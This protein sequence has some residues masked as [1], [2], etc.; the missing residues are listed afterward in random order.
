MTSY[1]ILST[2]H[3]AKGQEW[4]AVHVLNVVDGCIPSDMATG[5]TEELEE[6]R[7]LLYVAMTRARDQLHLLVP[8]RFYVSQQ[9]G[10]GD[11]HVYAG[12]T[13]FITEA[14]A[15]LRAAGLAGSHHGTPAPGAQPRAADPGACALARR[16]EVGQLDPS[17][18]RAEGQ[19]EPLRTA[20]AGRKASRAPSRPRTSVHLVA[21]ES[22]GLHGFTGRTWAASTPST[23]QPD[24]CN[25]VAL[26]ARAIRVRMAISP[27][28]HGACRPTWLPMA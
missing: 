19:I 25:R 26:R 1:L 28:E 17:A 27:S 13:R 23:T 16:L 11:R 2:I 21:G 24:S 8:Q 18:A 14:M 10:G 20:P 3:S 22:A 4:K 5:T 9:A 12:R 15:A 7:R 6:E